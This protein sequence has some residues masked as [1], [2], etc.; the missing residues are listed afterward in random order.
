MSEIAP[1]LSVGS[2]AR[3]LGVAASTLR[4]WDR[5]YGMSPSG[6]SAGRH[7]RYDTEDLARLRIMHRLIL[8]GAPAAEAARVAL[9]AD[10]DAPPTESDRH[11]ALVPP[12]ARPRAGGTILPATTSDDVETLWRA[13]LAMDEPSMARLIREV[14]RR[15]GVVRAWEELLVPVLTRIGDRHA[16][17][18]EQ[19][20]V[21]HLLSGCVVAA[22]SAIVARLGE[23]VNSRPVLLACAEEEQHSLPVYALQAALAK[24]H[25]HARML[26]ARVPS[27]SLAAAVNRLAPAAVFV[28]SHSP[29][30]GHLEPFASLP[31]LRPPTRLIV[32]GPGWSSASSTAGLDVVNRLPD[33]VAMVRSALGLA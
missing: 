14:L 6:R 18:G 4:S 27:R 28:W 29:D 26:G 30:T 5:R 21:E 11:G 2:A 16:T 20:E 23:S 24:E 22:L 7:R 10:L 25:I 3:R 8:E 31:L 13:T 17:G 9:A 12:S 33:A 15:R 32:G 1:A 19:I